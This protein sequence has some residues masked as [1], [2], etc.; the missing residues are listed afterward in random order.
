VRLGGG[1]Q[2]EMG[3]AFVAATDR[4]FEIN[5][6][7]EQED[8]GLSEHDEWGVDLIYYVC[9]KYG[10]EKPDLKTI[11]SWID[12]DKPPGPVKMKV[13]ELSIARDRLILRNL[14]RLAE[15]TDD[16]LEY[17]RYLQQY[18]VC[19]T[20]LC[21]MVRTTGHEEGKIARWVEGLLA[22]YSADERERMGLPRG[23]DTYYPPWVGTG[24]SRRRRKR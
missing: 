24:K 8:E 5:K 23:D 13:Q 22:K 9:E 12:E 20:R 14:K 7:E 10:Q 3:V 6:L 1:S 11:Y 21:K 18:G 16:P 19:F 2:V 17:V 15:E 4:L